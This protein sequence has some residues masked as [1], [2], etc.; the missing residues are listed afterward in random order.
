MALVELR[1]KNLQVIERIRVAC[2][3]CGREWDERVHG[4]DMP[5]AS[6][7]CPSNDCPSHWEKQGKAYT[8]Y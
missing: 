4:A 6:E 8:G 1:K 3:E 5:K 7:P 2:S